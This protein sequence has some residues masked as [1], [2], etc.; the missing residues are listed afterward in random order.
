MG[1]INRN[2]HGYYLTDEEFIAKWKENPSPTLMAQASGFSVRA[3]QNRRRN[4]E[5]KHKVELA[6]TANLIK[7]FNDKQKQKKLARQEA[8]KAK[9]EEAPINVRRGIDLDKGR[10]IV[11]SDAHFYPDDTTTAY[12]ALLKFEKIIY[13]GYKR[14]D[15]RSRRSR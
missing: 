1:T 10:I 5:I 15:R 6:T 3:V 4:I 9:L 2:G 7:E 13:Y 8:N 12:K 14:I 11:F